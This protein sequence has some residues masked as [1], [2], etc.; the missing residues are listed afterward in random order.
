MSTILVS[1]AWVDPLASSFAPADKGDV[2]PP[3]PLRGEMTV[4]IANA[5]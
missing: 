1:D 2:V 5:A 3:H 4:R